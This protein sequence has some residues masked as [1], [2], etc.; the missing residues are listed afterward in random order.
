MDD[1]KRASLLKELVAFSRPVDDIGRELS[2]FPWDSE[3]ELVVLRHVHIA[4]ILRRYL[5]G[6][7]SANAVEEWADALEVRDDVHFEESPPGIVPDAIYSLANPH[8]E[9]PLTPE[10]AMQWIERLTDNR[11]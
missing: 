10:N 11:A 3:R 2:K 7:L 4:D 8:L 5:G 1:D 9:G 6:T